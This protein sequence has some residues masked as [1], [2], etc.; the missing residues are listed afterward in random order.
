MATLT[1]DEWTYLIDKRANAASLRGQATVNNVH[2]YIFL[3]DKWTKPNGVSFTATPNTWGTNVYNATD[4]K[5]MEAAGAVFLPAAG[6]RYKDNTWDEGDAGYYWS[7]TME[8]NKVGEMRFSWNQ[9]SAMLNSADYYYGNSVRL[10][11]D[12]E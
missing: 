3:P 10:V 1:N 4:W 9:G 11:K 5:K 2:G 7:S 6:H 12:A 8:E